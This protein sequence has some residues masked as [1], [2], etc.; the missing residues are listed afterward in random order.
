MKKDTTT[1]RTEK[2]RLHTK[3]AISILKQLE[4]Q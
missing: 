2:P 4:K 3:T 1:N